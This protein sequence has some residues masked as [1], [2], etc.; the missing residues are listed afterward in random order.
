MAGGCTINNVAVFPVSFPPMAGGC[1]KGAQITQNSNHFTPPIA[2]PPVDSD[3]A[4]PD[5]PVV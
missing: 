3:A 1:T 5:A 4:P 2:A